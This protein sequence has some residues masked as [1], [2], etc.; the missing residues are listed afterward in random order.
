MRQLVLRAAGELAW[1]DVP[2]PT[3]AGDPDAVVVRPLAIARCDLDAPMAAAAVFPVPF[4]VGHELVAEVVEAGEAVRGHRPGERV[5]VPFQVSCGHCA[6]C[7]ER[8]FAACHPHRAPAGAAFGF[9]AAGGGHGGAVAERLLVPHADHMLAAAPAGLSDA[10]LCTLPDNSLDAYRAVA[11]PLA[12]R[13][14]AEV[15]VVGGAGPSIGL[16]AVALARALGASSVRY[17]DRD[18]GRCAQAERLGA[19]VT[20]IDGEWPRRF[21]R[22]PVVVENTGEP[23]GLACA[24]RST[25]DYG[26]LTPVAIHFA[27]ET[28]LPLLAMYTRGITLELGRADSRRHLDEVL[29]LAADGRFDPTAIDTTVVAFEDA[30]EAWLEA[31]TKLVVLGA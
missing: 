24:I 11:G 28:P 4:P 17:A 3:V 10:A 20:Q 7:A 25:D 16:Y 31:A 6:A 5:V 18:A 23:A 26:T 15:L 12:R 13:P 9:G 21:A 27:P 30:G 2:E 19:Q 8:R 22:A 14:G 29:A 1:E